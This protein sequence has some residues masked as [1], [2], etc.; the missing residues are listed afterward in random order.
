MVLRSSIQSL[1]A[2]PAQPVYVVTTPNKHLF[3]VHRHNKEDQYQSFVFGFRDE[4]HARLIARS[5]ESYYLRHGTFPPRDLSVAQ[6]NLTEL[7]SSDVQL[8]NVSVEQLHLAD[9]L[10]RL[11]GTGIVVTVLSKDDE[12]PE[13]MAFKCRDV[14]ADTTTPSVVGALNRIWHAHR[15][16]PCSNFASNQGPRYYKLVD[17][18]LPDPLVLDDPRQPG[19][20]ELLPKPTWPPRGG[21]PLAKSGQNV[22]AALQLMAAVLFKC[23]VVIEML[24]WFIVC[25]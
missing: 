11:K 13:H 3:G 24:C 4:H 21:L 15:T 19:V 1:R 23:I 18:P 25:C 20:P 5:L 17:P 16:K 9:L 10:D 12:F 8:C 6:M 7:V 22:D 14:R 2:R